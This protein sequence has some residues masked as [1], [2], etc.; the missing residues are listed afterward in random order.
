V[1]SHPH[2]AANIVDCCARIQ[3]YRRGAIR[4]RGAVVFRVLY[5][6]IGYSREKDKSQSI[7]FETY[8][9]NTCRKIR[10]KTNKS[11]ITLTYTENDE[12]ICTFCLPPH[13]LSLLSSLDIEQST[14]E[15]FIF[16]VYKKSNQ[17]MKLFTKHGRNPCKGKEFGFPIKIVV[18]KLKVKIYLFFEN[19]K[20]VRLIYGGGTSQCD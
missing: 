6:Q 1:V 7:T 18:L 4:S 8:M 19:A 13:L 20:Y 12:N 10:C 5:K 15:S 2:Y 17:K 3:R 11:S 14:L 9:C 16:E